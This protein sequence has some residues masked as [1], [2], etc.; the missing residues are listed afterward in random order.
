[1]VA[2][3][4]EVIWGSSCLNGVNEME[5]EIISLHD[6]VRPLF[7]RKLLAQVVDKLLLC[8]QVESHIFADSA[9]YGV[10]SK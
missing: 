9:N 1:M 2:C 7:K 6:L 4:K 8:C 10:Q 5:A 3:Q